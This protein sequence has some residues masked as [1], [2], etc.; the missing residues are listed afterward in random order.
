MVIAHHNDAP[1]IRTTT[2]SVNNNGRCTFHFIFINVNANY[3]MITPKA[4]FSPN[5]A[6]LILIE[7][8]N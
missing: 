7:G 8:E 2:T 4:N 5:N 1:E 6:D 3:E